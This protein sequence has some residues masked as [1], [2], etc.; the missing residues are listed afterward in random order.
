VSE[1]FLGELRWVS[2]STVPKGWAA[3]DG[4]VLP[5]QQ[6]QA[7]FALLGDRYGGNGRSSF[8][9]PD[10]RGRTL[11]HAGW[12]HDKEIEHGEAGGSST[13]TLQLQE[14][15]EY[16]SHYLVGATTAADTQAPSATAVL[17][18]AAVY[19]DSHAAF[20]VMSPKSV[21]YAGHSQPHENM[22]PYL[23]LQC[24]I[25]LT[26]RFPARN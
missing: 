24:I 21:G 26:G 12:R 16:H 18:G 17:A 11:V 10:L 6:N 23:N 15:P 3:C 22:Q 7:L 14:I 2:F 5:I 25:A 20:G 9:L 1:P 13:V 19:T 4:Q 8:A